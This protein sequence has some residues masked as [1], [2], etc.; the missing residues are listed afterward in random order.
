MQETSHRG[1][2]LPKRDSLRKPTVVLV[3]HAVHDEGGMERAFAELVRR[4]HER[5]RV[6][7]VS[8]ELAPTLR[9][10]VDW[11][12]IR[13]PKRPFP[14]RFICFFVLAG[15]QLP[16][17]PKDLVHA[18]GAI[19]PNRVDAAEVQF[20]HAG[21]A[22]A[23][24]GV[25]PS[26]A[27]AL[28]RLNTA[29]TRLLSLVA[30]RWCYRPGR[31]K[32]F[33]AVSRGV[34]CELRRFFPAVP[35]S[36]APNGVNGAVYRPSSIIRSEV[37]RELGITDDEIVALFV[38]G[39]WNRKGLSIAVEALRHAP[40][41]HLWVVGS[42][43]TSRAR[44]FAGKLGVVDRVRFFG[45]R[46]DGY[47]FYAAADMFCLPTQYET[48]SIAAHEAA[49]SGLPIVATR[50]S[51]VDELVG[52]DKAGFL[53]DRSPVA[54]GQ[55]L[56]RLGADADLRSRLGAIGRQ[57]ASALTW[58]AATDAVFAVYEELLV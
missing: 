55:A 53:V 9:P 30:E 47:R 41:V 11:K 5:Y 51:G 4:A 13:V 25:V 17:F 56:E 6:V 35:I 12:R 45:A 43:N 46:A 24:G 58:E 31:V 49:A 18:L 2:A 39:D 14:L 27:P 40:M 7:V 1:Q 48:F 38:G 8:S 21:F 34:G 57:R 54:V 33:I 52:V 29:I 42:G 37:R 26:D 32:R 10:L 50:V 22:A 15:L 44:A 20:C 16:R 36:L 19:V 28:R 23:A 3:A